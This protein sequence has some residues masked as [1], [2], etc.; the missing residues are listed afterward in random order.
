MRPPD[1]P[2]G[3]VRAVAAVTHLWPASM[4]PPDLPG[5]NMAPPLAMLWRN[6]S[7]NEAAGFTRRKQTSAPAGQ[8]RSNRA[9]MRP[10]DLPGGNAG[11]V[12][13]TGYL[14]IASMRP[15]DLPGGN[16]C[17]AEGG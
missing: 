6:L 1:L 8:S 13:S 10:P 4:R 14:R 7:F 16:T 9:S 12:R 3:N 11:S 2:G 5:G 17:W 15:P